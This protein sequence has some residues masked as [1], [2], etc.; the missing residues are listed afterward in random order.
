MRI[1]LFILLCSF[2]AANTVWASYNI[3][4][5]NGWNKYDFE[6]SGS[7]LAKAPEWHEGESL[8]LTPRKALESA[9]K[10][11]GKLVGDT[12]DWVLTDIEITSLWSDKYWFYKV[13]YVQT[14]TVE[15]GAPP[16]LMI[17]VLMDGTAIQPTISRIKK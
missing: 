4:E 16:S 5:T 11:L 6:I 7:D 10:E 15:K 12:N 9:R 3:Y 17:P 13:T 1:A 2:L 8:P 14:I